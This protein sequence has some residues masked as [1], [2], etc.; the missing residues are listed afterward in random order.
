MNDEGNKDHNHLADVSL[1]GTPQSK[2]SENSANSGMGCLLSFLIMLGAVAV[3]IVAALYL[4]CLN[5][6]L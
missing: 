3:M 2:V 5:S 4:V 1:Q 6:S